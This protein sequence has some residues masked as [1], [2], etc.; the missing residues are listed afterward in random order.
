LK[1]LR[2]SENRCSRRVE[3]CGAFSIS[4]ST[5]PEMAKPITTTST[6]SPT[7]TMAPVA[8][9]PMPMR[10]ISRRKGMKT[11]NSRIAS[12]TGIRKPRACAKKPKSSN[13]KMP[14]T[15]QFATRG[16]SGFW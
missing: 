1:L 6:T 2:S 11:K 9:A 10:S 16:R 15:A 8:A 3:I 4:R 14:T 13:R 7:E 12:V 5:G